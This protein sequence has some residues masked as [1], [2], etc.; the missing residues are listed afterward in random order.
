LLDDYQIAAEKMRKFG[1]FAFVLELNDP[2]FSIESD[3]LIVDEIYYCY[4]W[5]S[6]VIGRNISGCE[7]YK[8][9]EKY[10]EYLGD[11]IAVVADL[12]KDHKHDAADK[13]WKYPENKDAWEMLRP[14]L[15]RIPAES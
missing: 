10:R 1:I 4:Q 12:Q 11:W 8:S 5:N 15:E 6:D 2:D 13:P 9:H 3:Y 7:I 14:N